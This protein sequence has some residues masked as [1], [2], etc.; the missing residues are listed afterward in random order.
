MNQ[1]ETMRMIKLSFVPDMVTWKAYKYGI[2]EL[3][4]KEKKIDKDF[5]NTNCPHCKKLTL[6]TMGCCS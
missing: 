5:D 2:C 4:E 1:D 6:I 3:C